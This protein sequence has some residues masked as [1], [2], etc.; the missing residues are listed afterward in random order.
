MAARSEDVFLSSERTSETDLDLIAVLSINSILENINITASLPREYKE[1][2]P[3][4]LE[5]AIKRNE[6]ENNPTSLPSYSY[7]PLFMRSFFSKQ[8]EFGKPVKPGKTYP[9]AFFSN[10]A[11]V[12]FYHTYLS[13]ILTFGWQG[14][15]G[16]QMMQTEKKQFKTYRDEEGLYQ[17]NNDN[18]EYIAN[19]MYRYVVS[20]KGGLYILTD[21]NMTSCF[22][23]SIRASQPVQS[24]GQIM[25]INNN[26][27]TISNSSG[28]Y[29][30][31]R[32]QFLR[33]VGGLYAAGFLDLTVRVQC[34][35]I[36]G[37]FSYSTKNLG[38]LEQLI[39]NDEIKI[40]HPWVA[41]TEFSNLMS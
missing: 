24:A 30:P 25:I 16:K 10:L 34:F 37:F 6:Y 8:T 41:T 28:H 11:T 32:E 22:H 31:T 26:I 13:G 14:G 15:I 5:Q 1:E 9:N 39:K 12:H 4:I 17:L 36:D 23:N 21:K 40:P 20:P 19:G 2:D 18:K 29:R 3:E 35:V 7:S 38:V 33:T 27:E